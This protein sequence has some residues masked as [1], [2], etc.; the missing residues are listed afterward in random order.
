MK[1]QC[2]TP[3]LKERLVG[4]ILAA[5]LA[6]IA[7]CAHAADPPGVFDPAAIDDSPPVGPVRTRHEAEFNG[8]RVQY[9]VLAGE[10]IMYDDD[11]KPAATI[12]STAY[13]K[14][15]ID[16]PAARPI[17]FL[18]NGG[19]GASSS[20]LHLGVGPVRRSPSDPDAPLVPNEHSPLD[21]V[22]MVFVDPV[23]TGFT[24]LYYEGAGGRY[25]GVIEDADAHLEYLQRWLAA[26]GRMQS[27]LFI[28]GESYGG[29]RA[30]T[31]L[32]RAE[33]LEFRGALLLSPAID[34][35]A[36]TPVVGNNLPYIFLM[37]SMAA[38]AAYHHVR[39]PRHADGA[40]YRE[41]FERA[42]SF[43]LSDYAAAL[44]QGSMQPDDERRRMA[45]E[46]SKRIGLDADYL[47][48]ENLRV[49]SSGFWDRLLADR[50]LRTGRLDSR[51][52][53]PKSE[54][55]DRR[56]PYNDPSMSM[57][58]NGARSTGELLMEYFGEE[59]DVPVE[60]YYRTLN[61]DANSKWNYKQQEGFEVYFS[62][63]PRIQEA[64]EADPSLEIWIG[65]GL[66]DMATPVM[67]SRYF[68]AQLPVD[69]KRF[70]FAVYEAGHSVFDH[71]ESRRDLGRDVR[72]FV[73]GRL[74]GAE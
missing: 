44:Y 57:G 74:S 15:G 58:G 25:W 50:G 68:M 34:F 71:E 55:E 46:L 28:M 56:P 60:R 51:I 45:E 62:V 72:A 39:D 12:F 64:M 9:E 17:V 24:R 2:V 70:T 35:S 32:A 54:L 67:A 29:M 48:A 40:S 19:P 8:Q 26:N 37:P 16:N 30:A 36:S 31:M 18:F 27:P 3:V 10:T 5:C 11:G 63:L 42:A 6:G 49:T 41:V 20:P 53:G 38:T 61:L 65:G 59:L 21:T 47:L 13:L 66:F 1:I 69:S 7:T 14:S 52:T 33:E 23:G 43:A 4:I 22:D 73:T